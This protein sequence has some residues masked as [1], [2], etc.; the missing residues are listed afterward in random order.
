MRKGLSGLG[1]SIP[2][3]FLG[4]GVLG[5][6]GP[7]PAPAAELAGEV[8]PETLAPLTL[9]GV[10]LRTATFLKLKVYAAALYAASKNPVPEAHLDSPGARRL[11]LRFLRD[12][13]RDKINDAWSASF[14]GTEAL[15]PTL[16]K[17]KDFMVD[18]RKG[19]R[20]VLAFT[21]PD[22]VSV[23]LEGPAPLP[24]STK[25]SAPGFGRTLLSTWL[26]AHPPNE[27]LKKGLL[28]TLQ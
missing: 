25:L 13:D 1:W 3:I 10:G 14:T 19:D 17:L 26:G 22:D 23:S 7:S 15:Q 16:A 20:L 24:K 6:L 9:N 28:G 18:L 21:G 8:F 5:T 12:V 11:E 27:D 4:L 2:L